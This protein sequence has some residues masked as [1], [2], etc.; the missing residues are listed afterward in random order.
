MD[1]AFDAYF[2]KRDIT[3][4]LQTITLK[5][6]KSPYTILFIHL[7]YTNYVVII[8]NPGTWDLG[9]KHILIIEKEGV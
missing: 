9:L 5:K 6:F 4:L 7:F 1:K 3:S 8:Y 2:S